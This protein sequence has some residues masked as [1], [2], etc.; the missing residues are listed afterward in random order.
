MLGSLVLVSVSSEPY[1]LI[2][3]PIYLSHPAR[4]PNNLLYN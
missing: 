4:G 3:Y 2:E 1:A